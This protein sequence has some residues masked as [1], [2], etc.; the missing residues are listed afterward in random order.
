MEGKHTKGPW[1]STRHLAGRDAHLLQADS[2][3]ENSDLY[4]RFAAE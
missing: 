3:E 2:G 4:H 1:N